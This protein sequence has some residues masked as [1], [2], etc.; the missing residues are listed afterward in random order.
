M[1]PVGAAGLG[2]GAGAAGAG[3][4]DGVAVGVGIAVAVGVGE[5]VGVAVAGASSFGFGF[6]KLNKLVFE[7]L[8][9]PIPKMLMSNPRER[10]PTKPVYLVIC[11]GGNNERA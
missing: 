8:L 2:G 1:V 9:P 11:Y 3:D 10:L 5:G 4:G 7:E 6:N